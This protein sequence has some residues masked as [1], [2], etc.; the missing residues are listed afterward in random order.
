MTQNSLI[1]QSPNAVNEDNNEANPLKPA[2]RRASRKRLNDA[3]NYKTLEELGEARGWTRDFVKSLTQEEKDELIFRRILLDISSIEPSANQYFGRICWRTITGNRFTESIPTSSQESG[4]SPNSIRK[5][6]ALLEDSYHVI[7]TEEIDYQPTSVTIKGTPHWLNPKA[8]QILK[9]SKPK[10]VRRIP[11]TQNSTP[12]STDVH[13][14]NNCRGETDNVVIRVL[15]EPLQNLNPNEDCCCLEL[16]ELNTQEQ[17]KTKTTTTLTDFVPPSKFEGVVEKRKEWEW[18]SASS[19]DTTDGEPREYSLGVVSA[20]AGKSLETQHALTGKTKRWLTEEAFRYWEMPLVLMELTSVIGI[21]LMSVCEAVEGELKQLN[22][23]YAVS[24]TKPLPTPQES[25]NALEK[26]LDLTPTA[27]STIPAP[28]KRTAMAGIGGILPKLQERPLKEPATPVNSVSK[29][30]ASEEEEKQ[31]KLEIIRKFVEDCTP[32]LKD[33][34]QEPVRSELASYPLRE[35]EVSI[36]YCIE[37]HNSQGL[38]NAI[39]YLNACLINKYYLSNSSSQQQQSFPSSQ[40]YIPSQLDPEDKS[41]FKQA[42]EEGFVSSEVVEK[43]RQV[44]CNVL[45]KRP[46]LSG[47]PYE[48]LV[49]PLVKLM[50]KILRIVEA[51]KGQKYFNVSQI[52]GLVGY[53]YDPVM[54][55]EACGKLDILK[56]FG[57]Q[58]NTTDH[59]YDKYDFFLAG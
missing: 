27:A 58:R 37:K 30:F 35:V 31:Y 11:S 43:N 55:L 47:L 48:C 38:N 4:M 24:T 49:L 3:A 57:C 12:D 42:V 51:A 13:S 8:L 16:I 17:E 40:R 44:A 39:S 32:H 21:N 41:W 36:A 25:A 33:K 34:L 10:R 56:Y 54:V 2:Q 29:V 22:R 14:F 20:T 1:N 19:R 26:E 50:H 18:L 23:E 52:R 45:L 53:H 5:A 15:D 6:R 9:E 59:E 46:P 7:E 28:V